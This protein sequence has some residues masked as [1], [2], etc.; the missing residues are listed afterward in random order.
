MFVLGFLLSRTSEKLWLQVHGI[1]RVDGLVIVGLDLSCKKQEWSVFL[2]LLMVFPPFPQCDLVG[3]I[4]GTSSE[5]RCKLTLLDLLETL[6]SGSHIC[7]LF[8]VKS[9]LQALA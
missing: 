9:R 4:F 5:Y 3:S 7:G 8:E 1:E 2:F 6:I